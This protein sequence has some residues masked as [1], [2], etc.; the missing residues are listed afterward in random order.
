MHPECMSWDLKP[1]TQR[2]NSHVNVITTRCAPKIYSWFMGFHVIIFASYVNGQLISRMWCS[3]A[4]VCVCANELLQK[5]SKWFNMI[6][7]LVETHEPKTT[8]AFFVISIAA[9][10]FLCFPIASAIQCNCIVHDYLTNRRFAIMQNSRNFTHSLTNF[11][12]FYQ[13]RFRLN[14]KLMT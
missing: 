1:P 13:S 14:Q 5:L 7:A 10:C 6:I 3:R 11:D 8:Y 2:R 9:V 12:L 4:C